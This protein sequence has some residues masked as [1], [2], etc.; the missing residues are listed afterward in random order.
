MFIF[1]F[2]SFWI[3]SFK[4]YQFRHWKITTINWIN[5]HKLFLPIQAIQILCQFRPYKYYANLGHKNTMPIQAIQILFP[6]WELTQI[7]LK[8]IDKFDHVL[9]EERFSNFFIRNFY[10]P[11]LC[12]ILL[13]SHCPIR[14]FVALPQLN[15]AWNHLESCDSCSFSRPSFFPDLFHPHYW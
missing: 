14:Y 15:S 6:H 5:F 4:N 12:S 3:N 7:Q 10:E 11:A 9:F 8:K 2:N 1:V 13:I